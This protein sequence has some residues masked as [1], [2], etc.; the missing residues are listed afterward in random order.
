[1]FVFSVPLCTHTLYSAD[2]IRLQLPEKYEYIHVEGRGERSAL[3]I[4]QSQGIPA[5]QAAAR[6]HANGRIESGIS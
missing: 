3:S 4:K 1:M 6:T 2:E 5:L